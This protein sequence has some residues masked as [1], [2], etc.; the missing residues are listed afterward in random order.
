MKSKGLLVFNNDNKVKLAIR[1]FCL[2]LL[3][4]MFATKSVRANDESMPQLTLRTGFLLSSFPEVSLEDMKIALPFWVEEVGRQVNIPSSIYIY[5]DSAQMRSDFDLDKI[6]FIVASPMVFVQE[7]DLANLVDGYK[8]VWSGISADELLVVTHQDSGINTIAEVKNRD[9]MLLKNEPV[10]VMY[11]DVLAL[12]NFGKR[13]KDVYHSINFAQKSNRLIYQLFFKK[14]DVIFIYK[15][16]YDLA[17]ELNPQIGKK[18]KVIATLPEIPRAL[19]FFHRKVDPDFRE[20]VISEVEQLYTHPRGQQL[21]EL[22]Q[23]D[24]TIRSQVSDL[25]TTQQL[26]QQHRKLLKQSLS[27]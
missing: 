25:K 21:L 8:V 23:A 11:A 19:G 3:V 4:L 22:F 16:M 18:T 1:F 6:N 17:I 9:L 14:T 24:K 7:F 15:I 5:Q 2:S 13:S 27:R 26:N 20:K 10:S 12:K